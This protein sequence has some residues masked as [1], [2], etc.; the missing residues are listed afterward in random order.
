M[1]HSSNAVYMPTEDAS[2]VLNEGEPEWT[3]EA[4]EST[5]EGLPDPAAHMK[6]IGQYYPEHKNNIIYIGRG[7]IVINDNGL[8]Y[9]VGEIDSSSIEL[10]AFLTD[11]NIDKVFAEW[12]NVRTYCMKVYI[13]NKLKPSID[14][15]F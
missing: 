2:H 9:I 1:T 12:K 3:S 15:P 4:M 14:I 7:I 8:Y 11:S 5:W 10:E 6:R 13:Y